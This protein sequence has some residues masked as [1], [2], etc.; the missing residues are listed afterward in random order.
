MYAPS[1]RHWLQCVTAMR[2]ACHRQCIGPH[3]HPHGQAGKLDTVWAAL[4]CDKGVVH[5][6]LPS[7]KACVRKMWAHSTQCTRYATAGRGM[8]WCNMHGEAAN[9]CEWVQQGWGQA[10]STA[11][12]SPPQ[13]NVR[14][15][16]LVQGSARGLQARVPQHL[17]RQILL[18][19]VV[20]EVPDR[21]ERFKHVAIPFD[22]LADGGHVLAW[23]RH[24]HNMYGMV[25]YGRCL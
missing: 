25:W 12:A 17:R 5:L 7:E 15:M 20:G 22:R 13:Q 8:T 10:T 2:H 6:A 14:I 19:Q 11:V 24:N 4:H 1:F 23:A 18:S 16:F 9:A 21:P 3:S